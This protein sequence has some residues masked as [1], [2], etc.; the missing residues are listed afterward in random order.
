MF[1]EKEIKNFQNEIFSVSGSESIRD[2]R[3]ATGNVTVNVDPASEPFINTLEKYFTAPF[4]N[5]VLYYI[6][7]INQGKKII[8]IV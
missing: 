6:S 2:V 5:L 7:K 1:P 3:P 8:C 4:L